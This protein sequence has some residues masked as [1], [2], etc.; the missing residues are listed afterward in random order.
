MSLA[1]GGFCLGILPIAIAN[2]TQYGQY[3]LT[4]YQHPAF[5][6]AYGALTRVVPKTFT[7]YV[8]VPKET[9]L[10]IA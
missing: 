4:E 10:E 3:I 9:R 1:F 7:P 6:A 5:I 2:H 8:P